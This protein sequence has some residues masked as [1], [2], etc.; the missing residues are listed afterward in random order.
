AA[1]GQAVLELGAGNGRVAIPVARRGVRVTG[2]ERSP[3]MLAIA[4]QRSAGIEGLTWVEGDMGDFHLG[5]RFGLVMVPYRS[6]LHLMTAQ[7]QEGCLRCAREHLLPDGRLALNFFSPDVALLAARMSA[8]NATP[9]P[10]NGGRGAR[11]DHGSGLA[12]RYV[13]REEFEG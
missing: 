2:L 9:R 11:S 6:F 3:A 10:S 7:S 12:M 13:K 5:T 1:K 8:G 4:R